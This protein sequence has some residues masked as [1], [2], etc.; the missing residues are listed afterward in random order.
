MEHENWLG[1]LL[2]VMEFYQFCPRLV[3]SLYVLATTKKLSINVK[4]LHFPM[5]SAKHCRCKIF[6]RDGHGKLI[7]IFL[8][9]FFLFFS[10]RH[11]TVDGETLSLSR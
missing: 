4:S 2:S 8:S 6:N 3:P 5:F 11:K 9:F 1:I 10:L 7:K